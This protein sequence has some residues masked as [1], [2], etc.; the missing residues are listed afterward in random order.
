M[1]LGCGV[2][3]RRGRGHWWAP[4]LPTPTWP[5]LTLGRR[6]QALHVGTPLLAR[7]AVTGRI[8]LA[9]GVGESA[10]LLHF[11]RLPLVE[12]QCRIAAAGEL[13]FEFAGAGDAAHCLLDRRWPGALAR[14]RPHDTVGCGLGG[15]GSGSLHRSTAS[16][17]ASQGERLEVPPSSSTSTG[18]PASGSGAERRCWPGRPG[19]G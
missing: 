7:D 8:V 6:A 19:R 10:D 1:G 16:E 12:S 5:V 4:A 15:Q 14:R 9:I 2:G 17:L 3:G 18:W 13:E 11:E